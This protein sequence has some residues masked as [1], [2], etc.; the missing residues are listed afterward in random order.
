MQPAGCSVMEMAL[1]CL[2]TARGCS[3]KV[4]GCLVLA[5]LSDC[6]ALGQRCSLVG[7][8]WLVVADLMR[9][10]REDLTLVAL[11]GSKLADWVP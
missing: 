8:S 3:E 7:R 9:E 10:V 1:G 11:V 6:S 5:Q 4:L 2:E